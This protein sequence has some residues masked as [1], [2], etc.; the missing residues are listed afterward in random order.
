M[1]A[2]CALSSRTI[3]AAD[4]SA[5]SAVARALSNKALASSA[6]CFDSATTCGRWGR[7]V[8]NWVVFGYLS[9]GG[10]RLFART[11]AA[12]TSTAFASSRTESIR[13]CNFVDFSVA[14]VAFES[15]SSAL[16]SASDARISAALIAVWAFRESVVFSFADSSALATASNALACKQNT[17]R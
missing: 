17:R 15:A 2:T 10:G 3:A 12:A 13:A 11:F 14:S 7:S 4:A 1:S 5:A 16:D 9:M 8:N 6:S